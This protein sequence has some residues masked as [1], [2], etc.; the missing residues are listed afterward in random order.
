MLCFTFINKKMQCLPT[1]SL[2]FIS[3]KTKS[4]KA[5][6]LSSY[7]TSRGEQTTNKKNDIGYIDEP[8]GKYQKK[9]TKFNFQFKFCVLEWVLSFIFL[10]LLKLSERAGQWNCATPNLDSRPRSVV[11]L[12]VFCPVVIWVLKFWACII[13]LSDFVIH[14]DS[15]HFAIDSWSF[16]VGVNELAYGLCF[17]CLFFYWSRMNEQV[18]EAVLL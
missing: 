1:D 10:S 18:K 11:D 8:H 12:P 7:F 5:N 16:W 9:R 4:T 13:S 14:G 3:P 17:P 15:S 6:R 2:L